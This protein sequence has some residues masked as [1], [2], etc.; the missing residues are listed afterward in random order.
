MAEA[1]RSFAVLALA[2][3]FLSLG[4][5][6]SSGPPPDVKVWFGDGTP[7]SAF[8]FEAQKIH[9]N[10][11]PRVKDIPKGLGPSMKMLSAEPG[12][13]TLAWLYHFEDDGSAL[14]DNDV[15]YTLVV[16]LRNAKAGRY[17]LPSEE[18]SVVFFC[19]NWGG[20]FR[21]CHATASK[22]TVNLDQADDRNLRGRFALT[23]EGRTEETDGT[24]K[25]ISLYMEGKFHAGP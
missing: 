8:S 12:D 6:A 13:R 1:L 21:S 9:F 18:V 10:R 3:G 20:K 5:C 22:G 24:G 25:A 4:A 15:A 23:M 16:V 11:I 7:S 14:L 19:D 17:E 2:S